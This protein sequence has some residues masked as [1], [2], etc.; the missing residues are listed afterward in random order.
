M[1]VF[2]PYLRVLD[3]ELRPLKQYLDILLAHE[4]QSVAMGRTFESC[5]ST[6]RANVSKDCSVGVDST[7]KTTPNERLKGAMARMT[8]CGDA[9]DNKVHKF[10]VWLLEQGCDRPGDSWDWTQFSEGIKM[11]TTLVQSM[12]AARDAGFALRS[13]VYRYLFGRETLDKRTLALVLAVV[14]V[15]VLSVALLLRF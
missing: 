14:S 11:R 6:A 2:T 3:H 8:A 5:G 4:S 12:T 13:E 10:Q 9:L 1:T 7:K 15:V